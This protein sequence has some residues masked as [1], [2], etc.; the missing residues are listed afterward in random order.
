[1]VAV[2]AKPLLAA[3]AK[4]NQ[5][6]GGDP[7]TFPKNGKPR[8]SVKPINVEKSVAKQFD[9][10]HGYVYAAYPIRLPAEY[11]CENAERER[12]CRESPMCTRV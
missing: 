4:R 6:L 8:K 5:Q 9:V 7:S 2:E 12:R 11:P 1:M 3:E 10:S